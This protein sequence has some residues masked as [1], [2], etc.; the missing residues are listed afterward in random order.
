MSL[1]RYFSIVSAI[2]A[3]ILSSCGRPDGQGKGLQPKDVPLL[4]AVPSDA[5]VLIHCGR[6][7]EGLRL[8]DSTSVLQKIDYGSLGNASMALSLCY[9]GKMMPVLAIDTG[10]ARSDSGSVV[11]KVAEQARALRLRCEVIP[12]DHAA[13]TRGIL[14]L[15]PSEALMAAVRRHISEGRSIVDAQGFRRALGY[16][17]GDDFIML[18]SSGADKF[19]PADWFKGIFPRRAFTSFARGIAEWVVAS[20]EGGGEY[21]IRLTYDEPRR[22]FGAVMEDLPLAESRIAAVA[23]DS[24]S[25]VLAIT[26]PEAAFRDAYTLWKDANVRL[27][28]YQD[29]LKAL[30]TATGKDPLKWEK[31]LDVREVALVRWDGEEVLLVRPGRKTADAS[32]SQNAYAGFIP[33][34]Y[35]S[36]FS[37]RDDSWTASC[38]GWYVFGS[39]MAVTRFAALAPADRGLRGLPATDKSN[40][41]I[42][43]K[44]GLGIRWGKKGIFLWNSSQ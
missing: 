8:Y 35:G 33:A 21:R 43:Y 18:R 22:N 16:A 41:F 23:P 1:K 3:F 20:P 6:L 11:F 29:V 4:R 5:L 32:P 40:H 30:K 25:F 36:A 15:T 12:S 42:L 27:R 39:E 38:S 24:S 44:P 10:R 9:S 37:V 19:I 26:V 13:G 28:T 14:V 17:C 34:L 2:A 31:E 7:H